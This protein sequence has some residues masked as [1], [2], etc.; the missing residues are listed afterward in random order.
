M[1]FYKDME[2]DWHKNEIPGLS[3]SED[4]S[5]NTP[6]TEYMPEGNFQ[7]KCS[8]WLVLCLKYF[9][10]EDRKHPITIEIIGSLKIKHEF[11][12][13]CFK[14]VNLIFLW[15]LVACFW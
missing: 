4:E 8:F 12:Y 7:E 2:E 1:L 10:S 5:T 15:H 14:V 11:I 3:D 9:I 6:K 13:I